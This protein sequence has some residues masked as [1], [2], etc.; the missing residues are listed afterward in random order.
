[1]KIIKEGNVSFA[2]HA[3]PTPPNIGDSLCSPR[4]YFD[5]M[6]EPEAFTLVVGGG[7]IGN[8]REI[9][10]DVKPANRLVWS[11]GGSAPLVTEQSHPKK[12]SPS[13]PQRALAKVKR[14][15]THVIKNRQNPR[16]VKKPR[17][18]EGI[19]LYSTRDRDVVRQGE[20]FVPC[21]SC[22]HPIAAAPRGTGVAVV[23]NAN[24]AVSGDVDSIFAMLS[25]RFPDVILATNAVTEAEMLHLFSKT[26][27]IV[28]NSYHFAYWSLLGGGAVKLIGYS[29]KSTNLLDIFDL[30]CGALRIYAMGNGHVL[31]DRV[32]EALREGEWLS[33]PRPDETRARFQDLNLAFARRAEAEIPTLTVRLRTEPRQFTI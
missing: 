9:F 20:F 5:F 11:V 25:K 23:L 29:T 8:G 21:S 3:S 2:Y 22:F 15:L 19:V 16:T 24:P 31:L 18:V 6:C 4:L 27:R 26:D 7:A 10:A 1:M 28:T 14:L 32:D 30:N 13:L 33:L 12:N 17:D